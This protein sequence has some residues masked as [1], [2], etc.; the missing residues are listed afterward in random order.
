MFSTYILKSETTGR[1]YIGSTADLDDRLRRHNEGR[2]KSTKAR[3]PWVML[4]CKDF[5]TR[6]EAI[7]YERYLK[8][9]KN[10]KYILKLIASE[11]DHSSIG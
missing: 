1:F 4:F 5:E 3:G 8:S 7:K 9:L 6:S 10:R 2:E 11:R